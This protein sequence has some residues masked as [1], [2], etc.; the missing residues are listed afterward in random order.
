MDDMIKHLRFSEDD[1]E[2]IKAMPQLP[3]EVRLYIQQL[4]EVARKSANLRVEV[5]ERDHR[6]IR[7]TS[8]ILGNDLAF[9]GF[10][11]G[12]ERMPSTKQLYLA[13]YI[14]VDNHGNE[15]GKQG[16]LFYAADEGEV[17]TCINA[18]P[19][20]REPDKQYEDVL[21]LTH[22][23]TLVNGT[24]LPTTITIQED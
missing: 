19:A 13:L 17:N 12:E 6:A 16:F 11:D 7:R 5:A 18:L 15:M 10:V 21:K 20:K 24:Q 23:L 22:G 14:I 4:E 8:T 2:R 3:P 9:L 1:R